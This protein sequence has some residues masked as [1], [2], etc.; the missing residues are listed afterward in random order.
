MRRPPFNVMPMVVRSSCH[1]TDI[2]S[3]YPS[4]AARGWLFSHCIIRYA[5][6]SCAF[7]ERRRC[8]RSERWACT[9]PAPAILGFLHQG[10][11]LPPPKL[12]VLTIS[13]NPHEP[14]PRSSFFSYI[15]EPGNTAFIQLVKKRVTRH[16]L[17]GHRSPKKT[18][19]G[20]APEAASLALPF[21]EPIPTRNRTHARNVCLHRCV[22]IA[23]IPVTASSAG[24][25]GIHFPVTG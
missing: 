25:R 6:D 2:W 1:A 13:S 12:G 16:M 20:S 4:S 8:S 11:R 21:I 19:S 23:S 10:L 24:H 15:L 5:A 3:K 18:I 7:F 17:H 22:P 14:A 9:V